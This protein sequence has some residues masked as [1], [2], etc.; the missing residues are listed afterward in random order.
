MSNKQEITNAG[1]DVEEKT[2]ICCWWEF[3]LVHPL[4][5]AIL[6]FLKKLKIE[7]LYDPATPFLGTFPKETKSF[8]QRDIWCTSIFTA[9]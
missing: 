1:E 8:S 5:K 6:R 7:L 4:W 9:A 2:P 3:K